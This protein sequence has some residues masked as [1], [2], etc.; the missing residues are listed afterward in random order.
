[1]VA[2]GLLNRSTQVNYGG[3]VMFFRNNPTSV[4]EKAPE[5]P[6]P[7]PKEAEKHEKPAE[8]PHRDMHESKK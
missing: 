6:I 2:P 7:A 8:K 1:M 5:K 3:K 4:T